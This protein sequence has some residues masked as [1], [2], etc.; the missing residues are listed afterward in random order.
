MR[1]LFFQFCEE[2]G[3]W[4]AEI[5]SPE[6]NSSL[7]QLSI[8]FTY[9][10]GLT[11]SAVEGQFVWQHSSKPLNWSNWA[12][13]QPDDND[14]DEDCVVVTGLPGQQQWNDEAC[15]FSRNNT[16]PP[17]PHLALCQF[18]PIILRSD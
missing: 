10:I 18:N 13:N 5:L 9:W 7:K 11:D 4:L 1:S 16:P 12:D 2:K 3:G 14:G 15:T 8:G 17:W 6:E